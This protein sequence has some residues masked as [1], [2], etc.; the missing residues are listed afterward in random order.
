MSTADGFIYGGY[1]FYRVIYVTL[2]INADNLQVKS[3]ETEERLLL[4][5]L[6][7]AC[8]SLECTHFYRLPNTTLFSFSFYQA[9]TQLG[10]CNRPVGLA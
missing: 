6:F 5:L 2:L 1:Y 7:L 4:I 9:T 8:I 3:A 10:I